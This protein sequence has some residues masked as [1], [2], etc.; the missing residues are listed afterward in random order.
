MAYTV[1]TSIASRSLFERA[2]ET[3]AQALHRMAERRAEK[4]LMRQT[5]NE[6]SGLNDRDLADIG[7]SR[8]GMVSMA[9]EATHRG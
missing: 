1:E 4:R 2:L 9:Y 5:L 3:T 7:T 6:L 8:A